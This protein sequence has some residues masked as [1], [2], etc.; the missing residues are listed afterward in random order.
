M[1]KLSKT[2][3]PTGIRRPRLVP[4]IDA[5]VDCDKFLSLKA[6]PFNLYADFLAE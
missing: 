1:N 2:W 5:I 4:L 3:I 6:V